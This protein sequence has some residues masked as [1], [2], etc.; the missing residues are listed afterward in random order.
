MIQ[1]S[2][3]KLAEVVKN[4]RK[5]NDLTQDYLSELTGINRM[6]IGRIEREDYIPSVPQ[7]EKLS[8]VLKFDIDT[9]F[10][11]EEPSYYTAFCGSNK[12]AEEQEGIAHLL[13]MMLVAKQ[14]I[15]LRRALHPD[16]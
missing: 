9:V 12:T 15:L 1:L 8:E 4:R 16:E 10:I 5:T 11:E 3:K 7:L 2:Q 6:M 13:N 14:Q